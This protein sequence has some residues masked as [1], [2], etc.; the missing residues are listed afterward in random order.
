MTEKL[1]PKWTGP[2]VGKMHQNGIEFTDLA[3]E[4]GV[5]KSYVGMVLNGERSP[6]SGACTPESMKEAVARLIQKRKAGAV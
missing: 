1:P 4:L 5:I 2:L 6:K 3:D